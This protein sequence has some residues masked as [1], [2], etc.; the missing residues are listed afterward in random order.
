MVR[1]GRRTLDAERERQARPIARERTDRLFEA[2]RRLEQE[3]D[4]D[5][6]SNAAYEAWRAR[7]VAADGSH[8]MAPG[9]VKPYQPPVA[10]Q[11]LVNVTDHDSRVVRTHGQPPLQGYNAQMTVNDQQH[12]IAAESRPSHRTSAS[13]TDGR[14]THASCARSNSMIPTWF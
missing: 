5:H 10:P 14:A 4:V 9:M 7:G 6:A 12:V 1:E 13:Q 2:C 3:L 11:G 8:R